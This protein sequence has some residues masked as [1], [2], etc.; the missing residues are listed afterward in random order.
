MV[1]IDLS[2]INSTK[3]K[4]TLVEHAGLQDK[5]RHPG[6]K[7][8][9]GIGGFVF[10]DKVGENTIEYKVNLELYPEGIGIYCR[11]RSNNFL[12]ILPFLNIQRITVHK[13]ED[14]IRARSFSWY[15]AAMK[16]GVSYERVRF[17][18]LESEWVRAYP[19]RVTFH[20][21][22]NTEFT[23]T[24]NKIRSSAV[25]SFFNRVTDKVKV[26]F[27]IKFFCLTAPV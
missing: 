7:L 20:T 9:K 2:K 23:I 16:L 18:V 11:S 24:M 17:L 10:I 14:V 6:F 26:D 25:R 1:T 12:V 4:H 22:D 15:K 5:S 27:D 13:E 19:L 21:L 8:S 3:L